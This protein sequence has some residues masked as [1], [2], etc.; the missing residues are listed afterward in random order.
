[1]KKIYNAP[2]CESV[3]IDQADILTASK[4]MSFVKADDNVEGD[5][6][7]GASINFPF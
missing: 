6:E 3:V 7:G 1:M 4:F 2:W 5:F